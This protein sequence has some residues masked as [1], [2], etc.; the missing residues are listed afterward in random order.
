MDFDG[1]LC[2]NDYP[3]I[4]SPNRAL[5]SALRDL[6]ELGV[7]LILYTCREGE[8][9]EQAEWWCAEHGLKFDRVN[10]DYIDRF[11]RKVYAHLYIEDKAVTPQEFLTW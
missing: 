4:G 6:R 5:L 1:T 2:A 11:G 3:G 7:K 9:L 8:E 10:D